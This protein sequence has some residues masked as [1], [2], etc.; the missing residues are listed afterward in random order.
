MQVPVDGSRVV[1]FGVFEVNLQE[2]ELRRSGL[3]IKL[4]EQP[5]RVL[6]M[7]LEHPGQTVTR[8]ELRQRL[9]P[10]N[11]FVDFDHSLNS[12]VNRLRETLGDDSEN[13]RFIETIPRRGYRFI[14][15]VE[16]SAEQ[17][18]VTQPITDSLGTDSL[19]YP[20]P[21]VTATKRPKWRVA[22]AVIMALV[23]VGAA[24]FGVYSL[25]HRP[26]PR[27][28]QNFTVAQVTHTG[29]A[30]QAAIS[31]DGK[32]V[33]SAMKDN[34]LESLWLRNIPTGSDTQVIPPS[35]SHYENLAFSPDGNYI[36]FSRFDS[37]TPAAGVFRMPVLGG[38]PRLIARDAHLP[39][40][41]PDGMRIAYVRP[42]DPKTKTYTIWTASSD[43][44][45]EAEVQSRADE[46]QPW[47]L[48]WSPRGDE[49]FFSVQYRS[50]HVSVIDALH[51]ATGKWRRFATLKTKLAQNMHWSPD[52]QTLLVL[53]SEYGASGTDGQIGF[54][55]AGDDD[56]RPITR[57]SNTYRNLTL[58]ADGSA[59]AT[60]LARS[61]A[62]L[63]ILPVPSGRRSGTGSQETDR[64]PEPTSLLE[65]SNRGDVESLGWTPDGK[66]LFS[67]A[68]QILKLSPDGKRREQLLADPSA[69]IYLPS[70]CGA[71]YLVLT[72]ALH[73]G[74]PGYGLWRTNAD[75]SSPVQLTPGGKDYYSVCSPDQKAVY[76]V[77]S[78]LGIFRVALD[79]SGKPEAL[80]SVPEGYRRFSGLSVS[81]DGK[82]LAT[83]A[84]GTQGSN[85]KIALFELGSSAPP[86]MFDARRY[87]ENFLGR[88]LEFTPDG[89][90]VAYVGRENGVDNLWAQPLDGSAGHAITDFKSEQIWSFSLSPDGKSLAVLRGHLDSDVVLLQETK[91]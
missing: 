91:Q 32:Y 19:A 57:D 62:A 61:P 31:S 34:E 63:S 6:S 69:E 55:R 20:Q 59:L 14:A 28:F 15:P 21:A 50:R 89:K 86:R 22:P 46:E 18:S 82:M 68:G 35:V 27:P 39:A 40:I 80:Y 36:Y 12:S 90:S 29:K 24:S 77:G 44:S 56:V 64:M 54:L 73:G 43:G 58:S 49:V 71:N 76:Y 42:T 75:G 3:R 79:G 67:D 85:T 17:R 23:V 72:W 88:R 2:A 16:R 66:L 5:F 52:K 26:A 11:T 38:T 45:N 25:L 4:Q 70:A 1:C 65:Q 78:W 53:Y 74:K 13:P 84:T 60:V 37:P 8:E 10:A 87:S 81:P 33:V 30:L 41:S 7:L 47:A 51:V 48:T 83:V 9:W